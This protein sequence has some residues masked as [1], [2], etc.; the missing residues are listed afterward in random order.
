MGVFNADTGKGF[1]WIQSCYMLWSRRERSRRRRRR[2]EETERKRTRRR[3][4][5]VRNEEEAEE[6]EQE[7]DK[8]IEIICAVSIFVECG[9]SLV[10]LLLRNFF[11]YLWRGLQPLLAHFR[12]RLLFSKMPPPSCLLCGTALAELSS[13]SL[14]SAWGAERK[15]S[16]THACRPVYQ[17][18]GFSQGPYYGLMRFYT[19][20]ANL[21]IRALLGPY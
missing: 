12:H 3:R 13:P 11:V 17:K 19:Y 14:R 21:G 2:R 5:E 4:E 6:E 18:Y 20:S 1:S 16:G 15:L 7:E 10:L 8:R 9:C